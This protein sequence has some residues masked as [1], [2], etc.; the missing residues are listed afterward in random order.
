MIT[1]ASTTP[2]LGN[3]PMGLEF[4]PRLK[5]CHSPSGLSFSTRGVRL[6][7]L[8]DC[9]GCKYGTLDRMGEDRMKCADCGRE[10]SVEELKRIGVLK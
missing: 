6:T 2:R 5:N 3:E 9:P 10:Y 7:S 1:N 8:T 4:R